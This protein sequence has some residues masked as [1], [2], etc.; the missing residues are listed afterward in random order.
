[1]GA[2]ASLGGTIH[3][4]SATCKQANKAETHDARMSIALHNNGG[5]TYPSGAINSLCRTFLPCR[6]LSTAYILCTVVKRPV[7]SCY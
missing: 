7:I 1:M 6:P 3:K 5:T 2:L 4:S